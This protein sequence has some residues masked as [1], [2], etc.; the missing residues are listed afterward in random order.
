MATQLRR[1][2]PASTPPELNAT[3]CA[4]DQQAKA[5]RYGCSVPGVSIG[6]HHAQRQGPP[7]PLLHFSGGAGKSGRER[8]PVALLLSRTQAE[9]LS[10]Q[11]LERVPSLCGSRFPFRG[12]D[13][14]ATMRGHTVRIRVDLSRERIARP[15]PI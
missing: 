8:D 7:D 11:R 1:V 14:A 13:R 15:A 3:S 2:A 5:R 9:I 12:T 10:E 6:E 4:D